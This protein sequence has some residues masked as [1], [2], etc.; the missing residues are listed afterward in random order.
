ML[1]AQAH[2]ASARGTCNR[3]RVGAVIAQESRPISLGYNGAPP[4]QDHCG[5]DCNEHNP[6]KNTDH[7]EANAIDWARKFGVWVGG[8]TLYVTDSP[9]RECAEKIYLA[10]IKRVVYDRQ[11]R[12]PAGIRYLLSR[13]IK[14]EQCRVS[15]VINANSLSLLTTL[16]S[17]ES[18]IDLPE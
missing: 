16:V 4:G 13:N 5:S 1:M 7:A 14:V 3:L 11:Y 8:A 10:G 2:I 17:K 15:H 9:C 12:N 6:C 18:V